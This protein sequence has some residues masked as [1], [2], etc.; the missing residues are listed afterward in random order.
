MHAENV[1]MAQPAVGAV[2]TISATGS[3]LVDPDMAV[4]LDAVSQEMA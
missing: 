4:T 3:C 1:R 2:S